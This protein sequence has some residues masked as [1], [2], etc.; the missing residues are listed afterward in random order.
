M[1]NKKENSA[2][3]VQKQP[4]KASEQNT[5]FPPF[6][7]FPCG[8]HSEEAE[9]TP[10]PYLNIWGFGTLLKGTSAEGIMAPLSTLTSSLFKSELFFKKLI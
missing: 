3:N 10:G 5:F 1:K 2:M 6:S 7:Y 9:N 8:S 4:L